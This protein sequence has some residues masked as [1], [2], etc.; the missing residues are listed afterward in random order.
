MYYYDS[1]STIKE[2]LRR[3][4]EKRGMINLV[5]DEYIEGKFGIKKFSSSIASSVLGSITNARM[6]LDPNASYGVLA[7]QVPGACIEDL[8]CYMLSLRLGLQPFS[9]AFTRDAF[10]S[11]SNDKLFRLKVPFTSLSKKGNLQVNYKS[12]VTNTNGHSYTDLNMMRM[13]WFKVGEQSLSNYHCDMQQSVF[14]HSEI[15][16]LWGDIS[17]TWG[18]ILAEVAEIG[19]SP[20]KV[21]R[22]DEEGRDRDWSAGYTSEEAR[23]LR[24][25]PSSKWYYA[26]YLSMFLDGRF[27]LLETYDNE[28]GGVPEARILFEK[29]MNAINEATGFMPLVV[30]TYPLRQDMLYV[31]QHII[32]SPKR[33][34]E[35][36]SQAK[37]WSDDTVPMTRWFADQAIQFRG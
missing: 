7:R 14:S 26:L 11:G 15:P 30:K 13:D 35:M 9:L 34:V 5:V 36:M 19:M 21:W 17:S 22:H 18:K 37:Y 23:N 33:A 6:P 1:V 27:V 2:E 12:V 28:A 16:Y 24:V 4:N 29:E 20:S 8:A 3:R 25:R 31:N 10:H 32:D